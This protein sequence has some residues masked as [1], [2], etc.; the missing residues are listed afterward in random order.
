VGPLA[1]N[2]SE[3]NVNT[4]PYRPQWTAAPLPL[5]MN[6]LDSDTFGPFTVAVV[7]GD[8]HCP[9]PLGLF[10]WPCP[11]GAAPE[12]LWEEHC[13]W[14][15]SQMD[16]YASAVS[17]LR[18]RGF[19]VDV[20]EEFVGDDPSHCEGSPLLDSILGTEFRWFAPVQ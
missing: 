20:T 2:T 10:L 15:A 18:A 13:A 3:V 17:W 5:G 4:H 11:A 1:D 6:Y 16:R 7:A 14:F 19:V 9:E 12:V 8:E